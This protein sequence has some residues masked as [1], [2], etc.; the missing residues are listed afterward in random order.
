MSH[1]CAF[2]IK[3]GQQAGSFEKELNEGCGNKT[4]VSDATPTHLVLLFCVSILAVNEEPEGRSCSGMS[5]SFS[6]FRAG[7]IDFGCCCSVASSAG[8]SS[9]G[10][11]ACET[12]KKRVNFVNFAVD[13]LEDAASSFLRVTLI[14][15]LHFANLI[16]SQNTNFGRN[17]FNELPMQNK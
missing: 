11:F 17:N 2:D 5:K 16:K 9:L 12:E 1:R 15:A 13:C 6:S 7:R 14:N 8:V 3:P 10:L 4:D